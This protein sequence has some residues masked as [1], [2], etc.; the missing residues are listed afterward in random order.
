LDAPYVDDIYIWRFPSIVDKVELKMFGNGLLIRYVPG[1]VIT[2]LVTFQHLK[3]QGG[4]CR[5]VEPDGEIIGLDQETAF[6][7]QL[8]T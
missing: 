8:I 5:T 6:V 4:C 7:G 1:P 3:S 2:G